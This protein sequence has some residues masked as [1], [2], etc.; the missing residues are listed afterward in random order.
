MWSLN[1]KWAIPTLTAHR[2]TSQG[3]EEILEAPLPAIVTAQ[4]GLL[5]APLCVAQGHHAAKK[6]AIDIRTVA[7]LGLD[8]GCMVLRTAGGGGGARVAGREERPV[9]RSMAADAAPPRARF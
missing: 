6:V 2:E 7:D 3:A 4:K 8:E 5:R 9:A 1:S